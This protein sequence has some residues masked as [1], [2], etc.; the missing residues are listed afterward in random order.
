MPTARVLRTT[1]QKDGDDHGQWAFE[2]QDVPLGLDD[3]GDIV[4]S[5]VVV[6]APMPVLGSAVKPLGRVET[7]VN[8]VIQEFATAQV[9][10]IELDAVIAEAAKR[11]PEPEDGKRDTRKQHAKRALKSLTTGDEAPYF[12][13]DDGTLS[14]G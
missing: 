7:I 14:V 9:T 4:S 6:E 3:D 1:K 10:G 13:E 11:L 2:L 12:L 5:C 8:Q